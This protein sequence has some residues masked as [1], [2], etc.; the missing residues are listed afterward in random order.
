MSQIFMVPGTY[1][2]NLAHVETG[3][4]ASR[5]YAEGEFLTWKGVLHSAKT[6]ISTGETFVEG[7]NV[8]DESDGGLANALNS[9]SNRITVVQPTVINSEYRASYPDGFDKN[10]TAMIG[11]GYKCDNGGTWEWRMGGDEPWTNRAFITLFD[12]YIRVSLG[13]AGG[14][15]TAP[16]IILY[17]MDYGIIQW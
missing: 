5:N 1:D 16:F 12:S 2:E 17:R 9:N 15:Y 4:V 10:N 14:G 3:D 7:T 13:G 6:A 8:Q 11:Y